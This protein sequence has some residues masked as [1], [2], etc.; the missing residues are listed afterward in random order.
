MEK[1]REII[2]QIEETKKQFFQN[3]RIAVSYFYEILGYRDKHSLTRFLKMNGYE[4]QTTRIKI[5]KRSRL[6]YTINIS[7]IVDIL[8]KNLSSNADWE[9]EYIDY[10]YKQYKLV[11]FKFEDSEKPKYRSGIGIH[12][13]IKGTFYSYSLN[14]ISFSK[15]V[16]ICPF[17]SYKL[18]IKNMGVPYLRASID[19]DTKAPYI[20]FDSIDK[21]IR[22]K[23]ISFIDLI[24]DKTELTNYQKVRIKAYRIA[25]KEMLEYQDNIDTE[26][27]KRKR[28]TTVDNDHKL[29][30]I[31]REASKY[32]H[33]DVNKTIEAE[34]IMKQINNH[35]ERKDYHSIK[36]I[37]DKSKR[38]M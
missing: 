33:P 26:T 28:K 27:A 13:N 3:K 30:T 1:Y 9:N 31:Y 11:I 37:M 23:F 17:E 24:F 19:Y 2:N 5:D 18:G 15:C 4:L 21:S 8:Y 36:N 16:G 10:F 7:D 29:K 22:D 35:Y 34:E 20:C 14:S 12:E 25:I 38:T 32:F 6:E